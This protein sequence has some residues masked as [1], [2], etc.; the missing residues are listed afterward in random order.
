MTNEEIYIAVHVNLKP[1]QLSAT[2]YEEFD[3]WLREKGLGDDIE[4]YKLGNS[5]TVQRVLECARGEGE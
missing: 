2:R 4:A 5:Y 1:V 3:S